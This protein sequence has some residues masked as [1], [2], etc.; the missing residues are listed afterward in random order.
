MYEQALN[1]VNEEKKSY[2]LPARGCGSL[3]KFRKAAGF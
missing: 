2:L 3:F 1:D